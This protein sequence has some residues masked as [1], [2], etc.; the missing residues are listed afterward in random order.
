MERIGETTV[1]KRD[2]LYVLL[3]K[4]NIRPDGFSLDEWESKG[5]TEPKKIQDSPL[6]GKLS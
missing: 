6:R 4:M 1:T 2:E 3:V 5:F